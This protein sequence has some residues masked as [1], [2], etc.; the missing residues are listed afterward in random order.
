[1]NPAALMVLSVAAIVGGLVLMIRATA[2]RRRLWSDRTT[3]R[4]A[5]AAVAWT[6]LAGIVLLFAPTISTVSTSSSRP[7]SSTGTPTEVVTT[8]SRGTLLE[9]EGAGVIVVLLVPVTVTLVGA[10]GDGPG[11]RRRIT[12]GSVMVAASMLSSAS[13]GIFYLPAAATLLTAGLKTR[14]RTAAPRDTRHAIPPPDPPG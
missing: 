3:G 9:H 10:L 11:R 4:L 1:M 2:H 12:T 7:V 13:F 6:V 8:T 5:W 14:R